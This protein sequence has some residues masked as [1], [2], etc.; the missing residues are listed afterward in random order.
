M[1]LLNAKSQHYMAVLIH[2]MSTLSFIS[3]EY[4]LGKPHTICT[5]MGEESYLC[6]EPE[7]L[8]TQPTPLSPIST[9]PSVSGIE[10]T[11]TQADTIRMG[12][13]QAT[14]QNKNPLYKNLHYLVCSCTHV[15]MGYTMYCAFLC[16][17][18]HTL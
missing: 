17:H 18:T 7:F 13:S 4:K 6:Q 2:A 3:I 14:M 11:L 15:N 5:V 16:V 1:L 9:I 12:F 10:H 8:A